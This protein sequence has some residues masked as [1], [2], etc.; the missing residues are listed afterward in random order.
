MPKAERYRQHLL[1]LVT[2]NYTDVSPS[3]QKK[4]FD[5]YLKYFEPLA[6]LQDLSLSE[7]RKHLSRL[8]LFGKRERERERE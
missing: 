6:A 3:L 1:I 4:L 7:E 5:N 2:Q 8:H